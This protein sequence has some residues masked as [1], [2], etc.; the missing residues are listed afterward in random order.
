LHENLVGFWLPRCADLEHGGFL[1][2]FGADG[3]WSGPKP[4]YL[5]SQARFTWFFARLAR[6]EGA[7]PEARILAR[8]GCEFL[9]GPMADPE[10]DGFFW[11]VDHTGREPVEVEKRVYGHAFALYA[12]AECARLPDMQQAATGAERLVDVLDRQFHDPVHGG[13]VRSRIR[14]WSSPGSSSPHWAGHR[15]SLNDHIHLLEAFLAHLP[16]ASGSTTRTR[17]LETAFLIGAAADPVA[18]SWQELFEPDWSPADGSGQ[19][20]SSYGHDFETAWMLFQAMDA[21]GLPSTIIRRPAHAAIRQALRHGVDLRRGGVYESGPAGRPADRCEKI[22]WVQAEALL[23][24][25]H[26]Y[27]RTGAPALAEMYLSTLDWV[28]H[29]QVDWIVGEWHHTVLASGRVSGN[30]GG[31]WKDPYHQGR[32]LIDCLELLGA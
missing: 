28:E 6:A 10:W 13:Y 23:S 19:P 14:D 27:V 29:S 8:H 4:K 5:V 3:R 24:A 7:P 12:L 1:T 2:H 9:L 15:K 25:L 30:K 18:V 20:R 17:L 16:M 26:L 31:D 32:A 21:V 22:W 11:T